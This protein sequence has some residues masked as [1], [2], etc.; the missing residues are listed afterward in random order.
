MADTILTLRQLEDIFRNLTCTILGLD[1]TDPLNAG[2]VRIAWP[3]GSG[4]PAW[5]ITDDVV[6]LRIAPYNDPYAQQM[7]T[8][9]TAGSSDTSNVETA[10]TRVYSVYW[11]VYGP[12]SFDNVE[13]IRNGLYSS[14]LSASNLY[15]VLDMPVPIRDPEIFDGRWWERSDLSARF[16]ELVQRQGIVPTISSVNIQIKTEEGVTIDANSTT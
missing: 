9:Y 10:Y 2:K 13:T 3:S 7:G 15:V 4:A 11:I 1:P 5:K 14:D 16:N 6:F 12:N 8:I